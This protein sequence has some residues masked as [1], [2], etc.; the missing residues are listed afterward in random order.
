MTQRQRLEQYSH[1]SRSIWRHQKLEK[2]RKL[3]FL[4]AFRQS[5]VLLTHYFQTSGLHNCERINVVFSQ[6]CP[7]FLHCFSLPSSLSFLLSLSP[8]L[9]LSSLLFL[10]LFCT[11]TRVCIKQS[12]IFKSGRTVS[13]YVVPMDYTV[14]GIL[15]ARILEWVA[16]L[17]LRGSYQSR[18]R[19]GVS[20]ITRGFFTN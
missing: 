14:H 2:S 4:R 8:V 16:F 1:K 20:C 17:F 18:N 11:D 9:L 13:K 6:S 3:T 7:P 19:T 12:I 15:H 5:T 10:S